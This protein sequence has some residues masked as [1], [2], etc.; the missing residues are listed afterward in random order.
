MHFTALQHGGLLGTEGFTHLYMHVGKPLGIARQEDQQDAFDRVRWGGDLQYPL[1][2]RR[3][4]SARSRSVSIW[5]NARRQSARNCSPPPSRRGRGQ[6]GQ[7]AESQFLLKV[8]ELS[9]K[10][11]LSDAQ[12][13]RCFERA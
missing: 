3:S 9:R 7:T 4:T 5:A 10:G 11:G 12:A 13:D 6:G 2:P 1:S 8:A